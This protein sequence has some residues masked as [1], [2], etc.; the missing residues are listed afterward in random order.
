MKLNNLNK[1]NAEANTRCVV[2]MGSVNW[3]YSIYCA[4]VVNPLFKSMPKD[5]VAKK[6]P[7]P[8]LPLRFSFTTACGGVVITDACIQ[9]YLI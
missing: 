5:S 4:C 3:N 7:H 1:V 9:I 6:L 8:A 2:V